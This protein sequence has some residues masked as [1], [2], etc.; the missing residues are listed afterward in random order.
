MKA[1]R[2]HSA[3]IALFMS[4]TGPG[5]VHAA[6]VISIAAGDWSAAAVWSDAAVP[7]VANTYVNPIP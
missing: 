4:W 1:R 3:T 2:F 5:M 7:S 6:E